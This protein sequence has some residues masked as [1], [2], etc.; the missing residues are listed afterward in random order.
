M[1]HSYTDCWSRPGL[2]RRSRSLLTIGALVGMRQPNELKNHV[3]IGVANSLS[4]KEIEEALI[5]L[6]TYVGFPAI[7]TAITAAQEALQEIDML[8]PEKA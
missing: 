8:P 2:D 1:S 5:Q 4:A 7:A 3:K 6:S